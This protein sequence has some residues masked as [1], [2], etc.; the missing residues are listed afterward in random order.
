VNSPGSKGKQS[1]FQRSHPQKSTWVRQ[2]GKTKHHGSTYRPKKDQGAKTS[3]GKSCLEPLIVSTPHV[4]IINTIVNPISLLTQVSAQKHHLKVLIGQMNLTISS[5][6]L[7]GRLA[8]FITN[9]E[10]ITQDR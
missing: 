8:Q 5:P 10:K 9:W 6:M 7:A 4:P 2:G 3:Q 1:G